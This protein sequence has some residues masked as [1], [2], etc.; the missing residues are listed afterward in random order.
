MGQEGY[1]PGE[2]DIKQAEGMMS[3]EQHQQSRERELEMERR[4][5]YRKLT[6]MTKGE[7]CERGVAVATKLWQNLPKQIAKYRS[8]KG[9][10]QYAKDTR[11][12]RIAEETLANAGNDRKVAHDEPLRYY[13]EYGQ[14]HGL[15]I[16]LQPPTANINMVEIISLGRHVSDDLERNLPVADAEYVQMVRLKAELEATVSQ[17]RHAKKMMDRLGVDTNKFGADGKLKF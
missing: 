7:F 6:E 2:E 3:S 10:Y 9:H 15:K 17:Y 16:L 4:E 1:Q 11:Y 14:P 13:L 12:Q 8:G 5:L